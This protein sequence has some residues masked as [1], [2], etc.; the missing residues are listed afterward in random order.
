M[1]TAAANMDLKVSITYRQILLIAMPIAVSILVPQVNFITNNIFLSSLGEEQLA[2]AGITGVFYLIFAVIGFGLN[3]GMQSLI[4][5]RAGEGRIHEISGL[6]NQGIRIALF[7]SAAAIVVTY[8]VAPYVF[9][10]ALHKADHVQIAVHYL[11]IR[12]WGLPLLY[13]YQLRNA[14]LVGTNNSKY[15][16]AGTLAETVTNIILDYGLIMG[17]LGL[18]KVGFNGAAVSSII[19]EGAGFLTVFMVMRHRGIS[20]K[21][22]LHNDFSYHAANTKLIL[23]QSAPLI[24]QFMISVTSW[25][26]FYILIEHH[27]E[28]DLAISN[29]MRNIFGLFGCVSWS[30]AATSNTMV[31]NIIGQGLQHR[32]KELIIKIMTLSVSFAAIIFILLNLTDGWLLKVYGQGNDFIAA[33]IPVVRVVSTALVIM[34]VSTVW[35]N[36]VTGTGNTRVN[37]LIEIGAITLYCIYAYTILEKLGM[38]ITWGWAAEWVYWITMFIPSYLYIQSGRWRGKKI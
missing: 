24:V 2:V 20:K 5:R 15:L 30:F 23:V 16:I 9:S 12:I 37:L 32:V 22:N 26:F 36:A 21:L 1:E 29:T 18:P 25:E 3:N 13:M 33:A 34:S 35:L 14:V 31:S 6:F 10:H 8:F 19:A 11:Y 7:F 38:P 28:R 4:A 27:G 17:G